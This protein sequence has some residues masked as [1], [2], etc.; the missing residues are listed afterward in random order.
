MKMKSVPLTLLAIS[1]LAATLLVPSHAAAISVTPYARTDRPS[2]V[3]G[4]TGTLFITVRNGGTQ[5]FSVKNISIT[6]PWWAFVTD[7]WDGNTTTT[8]TPQA[9]AAG[10]TYNTQFTFT[11]PTD[12]RA[13]NTY[14]LNPDTIQVRIGT[15]V[16]SG[17]IYPAETSIQ[18]AAATYQPLSL[19][20]SV[21]PI[22]EIVLLGIA[23]VMLALVYMGLNK[24][25]KK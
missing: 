13:S 9:L 20:S 11:V 3:P 23:V 10:Q 17:N 6:Y 12:G 21:L 8:I 24:Q 5:A 7:H 15:D 25:S 18:Y 4:D 22:I 16:G 2:Y 1:I 14:G 19:T